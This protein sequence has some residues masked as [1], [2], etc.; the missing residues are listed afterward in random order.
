MDP[1][2]VA[3]LGGMDELR[4]WWTLT[5]CRYLARDVREMPRGERGLSLLEIGFGTGQNLRF[6]RSNAELSARIWRL[7]GWD[8]DSSA[9]PALLHLLH[10][11][12]RLAASPQPGS[13]D[14]SFDLVV[15]MD[16]LEHVEVDH[17][18][19]RSWARLVRSGGRIFLM[20]PAVPALFSDHD[21]FLGHFRRY[22]RRTLLA[23]AADQFGRRR[24]RGS[25]PDLA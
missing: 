3:Q 13:S 14:E 11:Q 22:T 12:D 15:A 25:R 8:V 6:L 17:E 2:E 1:R 5:R 19:L 23:V 16:V 18:A 20:V 4:H 9:A 10:P 7:E 24:I 21:R